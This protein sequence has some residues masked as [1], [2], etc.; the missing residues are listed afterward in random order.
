MATGNSTASSKS[1]FNSNNVINSFHSATSNGKG[2]SNSG[3]TNAKRKLEDADN[4][5]D[6][7]KVKLTTRFKTIGTFYR[8]T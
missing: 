3:G 5:T 4:K 2:G 1:Y 7:K 8:I 6:V